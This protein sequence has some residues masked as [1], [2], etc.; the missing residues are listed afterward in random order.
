M[1]PLFSPIEA[2]KHHPLLHQH[3]TLKHSFLIVLEND[4]ILCVDVHLASA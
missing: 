1:R 2:L 4:A 3:L